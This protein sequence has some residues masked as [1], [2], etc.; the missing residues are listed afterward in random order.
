MPVDVLK[1]MKNDLLKYWD[2]MGDVVVKFNYYKVITAEE[3]SFVYQLIYRI[4]NL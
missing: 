3:E 4:E 2:V 1:S